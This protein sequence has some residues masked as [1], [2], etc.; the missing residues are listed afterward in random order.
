[1]Q[2]PNCHRSLPLPI[3]D[4]RGWWRHAYDI[5]ISQ[6]NKAWEE[7]AGTRPEASGYSDNCLSCCSVFPL[8]PAPRQHQLCFL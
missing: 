7:G 3:S 2:G 1:M 6:L 4:M 8:C 5:H